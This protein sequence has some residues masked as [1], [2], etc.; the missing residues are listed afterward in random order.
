MSSTLHRLFGFA[1]CFGGALACGEPAAT[2]HPGHGDYAPHA[3]SAHVSPQAHPDVSV[4]LESGYH[5]ALPSYWHQGSL[6]VAGEIG[7]RYVV[8]VTN[9]TG[10]R[11]EA[12][13]TVDGRDVITGEVGDFRHQRGYVIPPYGEVAIDGFRRSLDHVAAFRFSDP[14]SSYSARRGTPQHV[15]VVGVAVFKERR[16]ARARPAPV[17]PA[18]PARPYVD[19]EPYPAS[20]GG[21]RD[22]A[23]ERAAKRRSAPS[24]TEAD[25]SAPAAE[26]A[27]GVRSGRGGGD[28]A[29][30][31]QRYA[32]P[33]RQPNQ[34]G[35]RYGEDRASRVREVRFQRRN[36]R[37]PDSVLTVYYDSWDGL[38]ARGVVYEPAPRYS[39]PYPDPAPFPSSRPPSRHYAPPPPGDPR[40]R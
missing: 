25:A 6:Y 22:G 27:A 24:S 13:V 19:P 39:H 38:V 18:P 31:G 29:V 5:S 4:T 7:E 15:G 20:R 12:V 21:G 14:G 23:A 33:P 17:T 16:R 3:P 2:A 1:L 11:V 8:R 26:S 40:P 35:T 9:R 10:E 30:G 28:A 34:L 32:P 37:R 36:R